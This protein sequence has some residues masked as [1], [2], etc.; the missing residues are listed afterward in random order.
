MKEK[1]QEPIPPGIKARRKLLAGIGAISLFS[2]FRSVFFSR[3]SPDISCAPPP[4]KKKTMKVLSQDG[5]LVEVDVSG[6]K[7]VK[8]KISDEE[9]QNWIRR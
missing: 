5:R 2:L 4:E 3:K 9:L 8:D 7:L 1:E 6:I